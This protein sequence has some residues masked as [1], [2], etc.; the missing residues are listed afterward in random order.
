MSAEGDRALRTATGEDVVDRLLAHYQ[1]THPLWQVRPGAATLVNHGTMAIDALFE[2][3][4]ADDAHADALVAKYYP[5]RLVPFVM[6][7][8]IAEGARDAALGDEA[9][10]PDWIATFEAAIARDDPEVVLRRALP[11][12]FEGVMGGSLHGLV[13]TGHAVR[14]FARRD[15]PL[16]RREIA[17]GLGLWAGTFQRLPGAPGRAPSRA[18][19]AVLATIPAVPIAQRV[20]GILS[21]RVVSV[22]GD[23][24][25]AAAIDAMDLAVDIDAE[26]GRIE[27]AM[28]RLLLTHPNAKNTYLHGMTTTSLFRV[29]AP[30]VDAP[31]ALG[32]FVRALAA[33]HAVSVEVAPFSGEAPR[34]DPHA[35][36]R[37]AAATIDDHAIKLA[38]TAIREAA[39]E[40]CACPDVI[41]L[42]ASRSLTGLR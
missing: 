34:T 20:T 38:A 5:D 17:F 7:A 41:L 39:R 14:M 13:R 18:P 4:F 8:A 26:I 28:A 33:L 16:R 32:A 35:L 9:Q 12:L 27:E 21:A 11:P 3:G 24:A 2:L 36:A 23:A 30:Y 37:D 40:D 15:T 25:F 42:A 29:L 10:I 22:D 6:G 1:A 31:I 19:S